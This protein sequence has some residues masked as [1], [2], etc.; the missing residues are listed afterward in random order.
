MLS[1]QQYLLTEKD[2][3]PRPKSIA[4]K[5]LKSTTPKTKHRGTYG[6]LNAILPSTKKRRRYAYNI[7]SPFA[8]QSSAV[9]MRNRK[10]LTLVRSKKVRMNRITKRLA[11]SRRRNSGLG[12]ILGRNVKNQLGI[13]TK[14]GKPNPFIT[15]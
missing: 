12:T 10:N 2:V 6:F 9:K 5:P 8:S 3:V 14:R 13:K 1:F 7:N 4:T 15:L 11:Q